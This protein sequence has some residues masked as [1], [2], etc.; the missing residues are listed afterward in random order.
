TLD[1]ETIN[2]YSLQPRLQREPFFERREAI[3]AALDSVHAS[4]NSLQHEMLEKNLALLLGE[5]PFPSYTDYCQKKKQFSYAGFAKNVR[6]SMRRTQ[7]LY[8]K[9]LGVWCEEKLQRPFG[10]LSRCHVAYLMRLSEFDPHF[11]K[12][13]LLPRL[14]TALH[15]MGI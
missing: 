5:L 2:F 15:A 11:P 10:N 3:G 4:F 13:G 1:G 8:R 12:D 6:E 7:P 9:H 14:M